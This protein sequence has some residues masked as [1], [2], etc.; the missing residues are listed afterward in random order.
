MITV[1]VEGAAQ[2]V[3]RLLA[4]KDKTFA[5][6]LRAV[7]VTAVRMAIHAKTGHTKGSGPHSRNRYENQTTNLTLSIFPGGPDASAMKWEEV[8]EDRIVGL[9]GVDETA[10]G[11][12]MEYAP[13]VEERFPFIFPAALAH[14][15]T[16]AKEVAKAGPGLSGTVG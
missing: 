6:V 13:Y 7:E 10:P 14:V 8:S 3:T 2:T 15:D 5:R 12:T 11:A 9:F 16:F 1:K 4:I